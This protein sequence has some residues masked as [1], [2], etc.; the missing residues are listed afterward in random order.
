MNKIYISGQYTDATVFN[1][2]INPSSIQASFSNIGE[3][4]RALDGTLNR[5]HIAYKRQ[6]KLSFNNIP[7]G[8]ANTLENIFLTPNS[9]YFTNEKGEQFQVFCE[10]DSFSRELSASNVSLRGIP[11]Y[12]VNLGLT[13]I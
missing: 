11:V 1:Y 7:S 2:E 13:E 5:F 12:T 3:E 6:W 10:K 4:E 9:F 8:V